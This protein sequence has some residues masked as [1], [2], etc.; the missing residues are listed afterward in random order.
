MENKK[1]G[2]GK[3]K[4][5]FVVFPAVFVMILLNVGLPQRFLKA[6]TVGDTG[7][8]IAAFNYYFYDEYYSYV[9]EHEENLPFSLKKNLKKQDYDD[10]QSWQDF[11]HSQALKSLYETAYL[12]QTAEKE[13][14]KI[15]DA[16]QKEIDQKLKDKQRE[17]TEYCADNNLTSEDKY[18]TEMYDSGMTKEEFYRQYTA[19]LKAEVYKK[20]LMDSFNVSDAEVKQTAASSGKKVQAVTVGCIR[21]KASNDRV[22]GKVTDRQLQNTKIRGKNILNYWKNLD[23]KDE[24]AFTTMFENWSANADSATNAGIY[25]CAVKSELPEAIQ[26]WCMDAGRKAG[27]TTVI[28]DDQG[29]WVVWYERAEKDASLELARQELE[30]KQFDSWLTAQSE[31]CA[32]QEHTIAMVIAR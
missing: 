14:W 2:A 4:I 24:T 30:E 21:L 32:G 18:Y 10:K 31:E 20:E 1:K 12:N 25:R 22:E 29:A 9:A 6:V 23:Q 13:G 19:Q 3:Q 27:D 8:S 17:I 7:Y 16:S 26:S 28:S 15:S 5:W 11:F